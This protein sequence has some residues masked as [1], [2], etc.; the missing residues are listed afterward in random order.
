MKFKHYS[1]RTL[2][3]FL[4]PSKYHWVNYDLDKLQFTFKRSRAAQ[5]GT[6]LHALAEQCILLNVRLPATSA[7]V[8]MF[9]NDAIGFHMTPEQ[10]LYYSDNAYG[11]T[12]AIS[13]RGNLLRIHDLKTGTSRVSM[14][15]LEIYAALFC[16][17]YGFSEPDFDMELRIY[18]S[19]VVVHR[20]T[21]K[22]I[23]TIMAKIVLFDRKIQEIIEDGGY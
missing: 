14:T 4:S 11:T 9:V 12:D 19:Q 7:P 13:F 8:N 1:P 18:Q 5:R 23:M 17:D 6:R 16:L 20:P 21:K 22:D 10:I 15:Q 3:A 2:H